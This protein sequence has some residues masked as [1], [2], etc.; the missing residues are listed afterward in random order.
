MRITNN[1][2]LGDLDIPLLGRIVEAGETVDVTDEQAAVLLA[3]HNVFAPADPPAQ[4]ITDLYAATRAAADAEHGP[5]ELPAAVEQQAEQPAPAPAPAPVEAPAPAPA[6]VEAPAPAPAPV[7]QPAPAPA[8]AQPAPAP[9]A[10]PTAAA[11]AE[12]P[13]TDSQEVTA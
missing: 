1:S 4:A 6:P 5:A 9:A 10:D 12:A 11:P 7:E 13:A 3:Q 8:V 2:P